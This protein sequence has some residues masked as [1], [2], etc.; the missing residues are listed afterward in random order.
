VGRGV[1]G[2]ELA[3]LGGALAAG[4]VALEPLGPAEKRVG[5]SILEAWEEHPATQVD[6]FGA[7]ADQHAHL[8][9]G[10]HGDDPTAADGDGLGPGA[11]PVAGVDRGAHRAAHR[12][13][14]GRHP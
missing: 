7:R 2:D 6:H 5:V 10:A 14:R 1:G 11:C 13:A 4:E 8:A 3:V 12:G 9:P